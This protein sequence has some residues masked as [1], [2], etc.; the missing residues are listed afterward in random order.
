MTPSP[1]MP[2]MFSR[3]NG[4]TEMKSKKRKTSRSRS[5]PTAQRTMNS[6]KKT[7]LNMVWAFSTPATMP[8]VASEGCA[9][10]EVVVIDLFS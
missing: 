7:M 2:R 3:K 4:I 9:V 8:K 6:M 1:S 10:E 5:S